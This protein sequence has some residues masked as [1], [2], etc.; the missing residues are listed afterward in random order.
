M[1]TP[2]QDKGTVRHDKTTDCIM[3]LGKSSLIG[4][5]IDWMLPIVFERYLDG[6]DYTMCRW[7]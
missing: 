5:R 3:T 2:K 4:L 1:W 7:P 6:M